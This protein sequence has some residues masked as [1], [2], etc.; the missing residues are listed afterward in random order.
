MQVTNIDVVM[1]TLWTTQD[2]LFMPSSDESDAENGKN[3]LV[4]LKKKHEE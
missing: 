4:I 3:Q 1:L 2:K